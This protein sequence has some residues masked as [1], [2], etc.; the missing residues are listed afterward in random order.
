MATPNT[1]RAVNTWSIR[2]GTGATS[3]A[4]VDTF[5]PG[6]SQAWAVF[7]HPIAG[8]FAVG[9]GT[10]VSKH[11]TS[12]AW[13]VRRSL[14]GGATWA[15][16]D[17]YQASSGYGAWARGIGA[18]AQGSLYVV[19]FASVP[20]KSSRVN[21]WQVRK[22]DNGG[23]SWTTV[24]DYAPSGGQALGFAADANGNLFV[25]GTTP[26]V[27]GTGDN[28]IVRESLGGTGPWTTVDN[29]TNGIPH[30]IAADGTGKVFVGGQGPSSGAVA[31][32]VRRN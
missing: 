8:T 17:V 32:T 11:S 2:K 14:D 12:Q 23:T 18:D 20:Y 5:Q 21:H 28:W 22:S 1:G 26:A 16:V 27:T 31:W 4:T 3:Y 10:M 19:G 6:S 15:T 7:D 29:L 30:A 13:I 25:T 9:Y 24:D